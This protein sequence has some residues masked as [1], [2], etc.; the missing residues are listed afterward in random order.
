MSTRIMRLID[1]TTFHYTYSCPR[2]GGNATL[3]PGGVRFCY[4]CGPQDLE[5]LAVRAYR[6]GLLSLDARSAMLGTDTAEQAAAFAD[7][8]MP[9]PPRD[10]ASPQEPSHGDAP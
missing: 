7:A 10:D 3:R 8:L 5:E 6:A 2:C 1:V 4:A 9:Q